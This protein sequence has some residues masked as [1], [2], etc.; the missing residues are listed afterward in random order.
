MVEEVVE[1]LHVEGGWFVAERIQDH[2]A[3]AYMYT[4]MQQKQ[5]VRKRLCPRNK[6]RNTKRDCSIS[7]LLVGVDLRKM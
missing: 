2:N 3:I 5:L 6:K 4:T 7:T 1:R